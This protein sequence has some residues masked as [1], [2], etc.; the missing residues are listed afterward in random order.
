MWWTYNF[1][2]AILPLLK[3][4]SSKP[5]GVFQRG[6]PFS[7]DIIQVMDDRDLVLKLMV[8]LD[9]QSKN[10]PVSMKCPLVPGEASFILFFV[11]LQPLVPNFRVC[12]QLGVQWTW[13]SGW[14]WRRRRRR[15]T[16]T[17]RKKKTT[18]KKK[19]KMKMKM[20][21]QKGWGDDKLIDKVLKFVNPTLGSFDPQATSPSQSVSAG[22]RHFGCWASGARAVGHDHSILII[23]PN[24]DQATWPCR[25]M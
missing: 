17:T 3:G 18:K 8:L 22:Q 12:W 14:W 7:R 20:N 10:P 1:G 16:T 19:E 6:F 15:R 11:Q 25:S 4:D 24:M 23:H 13:R 21:Y 2:F 5:F 9:P